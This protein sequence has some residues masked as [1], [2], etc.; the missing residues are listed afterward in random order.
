MELKRYWDTIELLEWEVSGTLKGCGKGMWVFFFASLSPSVL[1]FL[2]NSISSTN[3][4][5]SYYEDNV[6]S[7]PL[8]SS[9]NTQALTDLLHPQ[10]KWNTCF[11][12]HFHSLT[13]GRG[14][15]DNTAP[16]FWE[17]RERHH[18]WPQTQS[19]DIYNSDMKEQRVFNSPVIQGTKQSFSRPIVLS[20]NNT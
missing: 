13:D 15:A 4:Y 1:Y 12:V 20:F 11:S 16:R 18:Y 10:T 7:T 5:K 3:H 17:L 14:W 19:R 2:K 6:R 9:H 8:S